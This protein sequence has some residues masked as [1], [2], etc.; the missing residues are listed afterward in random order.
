MVIKRKCVV[1][2]LT[3]ASALLG[4]ADMLGAA[5][6]PAPALP[7]HR[8]TAV[9][10]YN[11]FGSYY[12]PEQRSVHLQRAEEIGA[13]VESLSDMQA[14]LAALPPTA[15]QQV[16]DSYGR[17]VAQLLQAVVDASEPET[18]QAKLGRAVFHGLAGDAA[19]FFAGEKVKTPWDGVKLGATVASAQ[20]MSKVI[21][22]HV[23]KTTDRVVGGL[24][25]WFV[26]FLFEYISLIKN[27]CF[28]NGYEAY[29]VV[30]L[31]GLS[32]MVKNTFD[33]MSTMLRD[34]MKDLLRGQDMTAR[35][36][37]EQEAADVRTLGWRVLLSAYTRQLSRVEVIL[38]RHVKHYDR[39]S[40][41]VFYANE[42]KQCARDCIQIIAKA[43][44]IREL[45]ELVDS[46]K[47]LLGAFKKNMLNLFDRLIEL[48]E[49]TSK[50]AA[51]SAG[52]SRPRS[53]GAGRG[54][55]LDDGD[56]D[57]MPHSFRGA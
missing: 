2:V 51:G 12:G 29:S 57:G 56:E 44:N 11:P 47:N 21:T 16:R 17:V 3:V 35:V 46:N 4:S 34:G 48:V 1:F 5:A 28:H 13:L 15:N 31:R 32:T 22:N 43:R 36:M 30:D 25:E 26:N 53:G 23:E 33:D 40:Q 37:A 39:D 52:L 41:V 10:R 49:P 50:N 19:K 45:D 55:G 42:I 24:W 9:D 18:T 14:A 8:R 7:R 20:A 6:A 38:D 27:D 54:Y